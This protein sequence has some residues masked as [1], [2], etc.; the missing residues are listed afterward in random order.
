[1]CFYLTENCV[2]DDCNKWC[3]G[4]KV[5]WDV[6]TPALAVP[7]DTGDA[8]YMLSDLNDT[9]QHCVVV[10]SHSRYSSTHR[11]AEVGTFLNRLTKCMLVPCINDT[12]HN[13]AIDAVKG[14]FNMPTDLLTQILAD[15]VNKQVTLRT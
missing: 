15:C 5:Q 3:I 13:L 8:Y 2:R 11:V 4:L 14:L 12:T 1:M 9:H 10:G 7:L 6:E